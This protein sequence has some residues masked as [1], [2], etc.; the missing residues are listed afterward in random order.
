[1]SSALISVALCTYNG[2]KYLNEQLQSIL[3]QTYQNLEIIIVDDCST[4]NTNNIIKNYVDKDRRIKFFKNNYNLGFNK[5]FEKAIGLTTGDF[6]AISDQDDIWE[7]SKLKL[8]SN[9]I[10]NNWLIF[11]NSVYIDQNGTVSGKELLPNFSINNKT[12]KSILLNNWVTGHTT[13]FKR[14]FLNYIV[15]FS[16]GIFYDWWIGFVAVYHHKITYLKDVLTLH[17]IHQDSV[18]QKS[19]QLQHKEH[20][21]QQLNLTIMMHTAFIGY[22][23]TTDEDKKFIAALLKTLILKKNH[24]FSIPLAKIIYNY[25]SDF[26]PDRKERMGFSKLN[27][28]YKIAKTI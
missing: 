7:P 11:S 4:D 1:M 2:E 12:Y 24:L 9:N 13:L 19:L 21:E 18:I 6:I 10:F 27:F 22:K 26:Y 25:Y 23:L 15:P 17:R 8:L 20:K 28:A 14:E 5:N 16:D 3:N